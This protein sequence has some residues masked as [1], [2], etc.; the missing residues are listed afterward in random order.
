MEIVEI[1]EKDYSKVIELT[2]QLLN[3]DYLL[4]KENEK[5][6]DALSTFVTSTIVKDATNG[7]FIETLDGKK[8]GMMIYKIPTNPKLFSSVLTDFQTNLNVFQKYIRDFGITNNEKIIINKEIDVANSFRYLANQ[9]EEFIYNKAEI[10][11]LWI[12]PQHRG[13]YL[14]KSLFKKF[15]DDLQKSFIDD[16]YLYTTSEHNFRFY[17]KINMQSFETIVYDNRSSPE[18]LKYKFKIPYKAFI[19]FGN[20]YEILL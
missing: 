16:F 5:F 14:S 12:H 13:K 2:K 6:N 15:F 17:E 11:L 18:Y 20:R 9:Y 10:D 8:I 1:K 19:Y 3:F 7:A 4:S